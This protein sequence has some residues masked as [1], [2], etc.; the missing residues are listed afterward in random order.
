MSYKS[1]LISTSL[2]AYSPEKLEEEFVLHDGDVVT[3]LVEGVLS[4][5]FSDRVHKFIGRKMART[6]IVKLLGRKIGFNAVL[7]KVTTLWSLRQPLQLKDLENDYYLVW[8]QDEGDFNN[9]LVG[10]PWLI[11][12]QYLTVNPWSPEFSISYNEVDI[13]MVWIRL[14]GLPESYYSKCLICAIG[15]AIGPVAKLETHLDSGRRGESKN[16]ALNTG[17]NGEETMVENMGIQRRVEK[18]NY[19]PW[20]LVER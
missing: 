8:F 15:Q 3:K 7:N 19:G 11:F 2:N 17:V 4:I 16:K 10:G 6:I 5:T 18:E 1:M 20:M 9:V 13:Q 12:G 14:W